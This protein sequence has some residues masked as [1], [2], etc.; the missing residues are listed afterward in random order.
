MYYNNMEICWEISNIA[1]RADLGKAI[2]PHLLRHSI[3]THLLAAGMALH[4][5]QAL[6]GH[7]DPKTLKFM[8]RQALKMLYMNIKEFHNKI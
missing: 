4:N 7:S 8:Q 5:V 2:Y 3:A 6:L 1:K